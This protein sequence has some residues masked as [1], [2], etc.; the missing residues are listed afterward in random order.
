M[1]NGVGISIIFDHDIDNLFGLR[2]LRWRGVDLIPDWSGH[3]RR[4][5]LS[6]ALDINGYLCRLREWINKKAVY[7]GERCSVGCSE[8]LLGQ[9]RVLPHLFRHEGALDDRHRKFDELASDS[10][11]G[12]EDPGEELEDRQ[13]GHG[14]VSWSSRVVYEC[15]DNRAE[16]IVNVVSVWGFE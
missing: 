16:H 10:A 12:V 8:T 2:F 11:D 6:F 5:L 15:G 7:G 3:H 13:Y 9:P 1:S 4:I 14:D